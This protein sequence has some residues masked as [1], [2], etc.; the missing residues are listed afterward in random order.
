MVDRSISH[1]SFKYDRYSAPRLMSGR[2]IMRQ[3]RQDYAPSSPGSPSCSSESMFQS[4]CGFALLVFHL[5]SDTS[6]YATYK[7]GHRSQHPTRWIHQGASI[8]KMARTPCVKKCG[9]NELGS[10]DDKSSFVGIAFVCI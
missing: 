5:H 6:S 1:I 3:Y 4:K 8:N 10:D 2:K 9:M 7:H